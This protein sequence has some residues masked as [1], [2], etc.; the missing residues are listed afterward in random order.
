MTNFN[1][2]PF[3]HTLLQ[4]WGLSLLQIPSWTCVCIAMCPIITGTGHN[5]LPHIKAFRPL[6][7]PIIIRSKS[8]IHA[9]QLFLF[10]L[11]LGVF[12]ACIPNW[13]G[14]L[15][16]PCTPTYNITYQQKILSLVQ[17][18]HWPLHIDNKRT[19]PRIAILWQ[20]T[21]HLAMETRKKLAF[22]LFKKTIQ[23]FV[24]FSKLIRKMPIF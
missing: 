13:A 14:L 19:K 6:D 15:V 22:I 2:K 20:W 17:M 18:S 21:T 7:T 10:L 23:H 8:F 24:L 3:F 1:F 4:S 11:Q 12:N 16:Q 9:S 5:L